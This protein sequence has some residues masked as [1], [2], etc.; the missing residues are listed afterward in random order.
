MRALLKSQIL[1]SVWQFGQPEQS[2]HRS[3]R[4]LYSPIFKQY[5]A[6]SRGEQPLPEYF[7]FAKDVLDKWSQIEKDGKKAFNPALWWINGRGGEVRWS[8]EELGIRSRKVA[9]LLL[10]Q[11]ALRRGD[12]ILVVLPR[13]PEW[14]LLTVA[15]IRTGIILIPG[16][17]QLTAKDMQYR[18]QASKAKCIVTTDAL[19]P[20]VDSIA[21]ECPF[22]QT[23]LLVSSGEGERDG[24]LSFN[25]LF[26]DAAASHSCAETKLH[27][28][29][30]IYFT[31]GTSGAPKM[32]ELSQGSLGFR[33]IL[34]KRLWLDLTP[35]DIMWSTVDTGWIVAALGTVFGPWVFG[36]CIFIH[37]LEQVQSAT[38]LNTLSRFPITTFLSVPTMYRMLVKDDLTS[39]KF[40]SL[41]HC[42]SGG[43]P[44]NPEVAEQWKNKTGLAIHEVYGQTE[45]GIICSTSKQMKVKPGSMGKAFPPYDVQIIDEEGNILP[46]GQDGEIAIRVKPKRPLGLFSRY[47]D[48]PEKTAATER[49]EFYVTGDRG[50]MDQDRYI[51]FVGRADDLMTSSGYRIGP[52]DIENALLEHPAVA[53]AAAVSSPDA[54]RGEVVKAFVVLSPTYTLKNKED[55]TVELQEHVKK[56]TA[57]YKYPRKAST[58]RKQRCSKIGSWDQ[59]WKLQQLF[60]STRNHT[61]RMPIKEMKDKC[62]S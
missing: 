12:R 32:A 40:L 33:S 57:P 2:F 4:L 34:G 51:R 60:L 17:S 10:D 6:V 55:L 3:H 9:N 16:I 26:K 56:V 1:K 43:E 21:N 47:V 53:E 15:C 45:A 35:S 36:S 48:N 29:M 58:A 52:F 20:A 25:A 27:D 31:S 28:P 59:Q 18:L 14:W 22:L 39:Y 11:C 54:L 19:A 61:V 5:E 23:K 62:T 8:F 13:I 44:L 37:N 46:P 30:M 7:N 38:I 24:W 41:Q 50:V 49:G 42:I